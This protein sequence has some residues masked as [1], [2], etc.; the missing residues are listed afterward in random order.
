MLSEL[1]SRRANEYD[2]RRGEILHFNRQ[3]T[4][5]SEDEK[6]TKNKNAKQQGKRFDELRGGKE[7]DDE[8]KS[9]KSFSQYESK[10]FSGFFFCIFS[11]HFER[12]VLSVLK[13]TTTYIL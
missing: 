1:W 7:G 6:N 12:L 13:I 3:Q 4:H 8:L 9:I 2:K 5:K 11:I 10:I